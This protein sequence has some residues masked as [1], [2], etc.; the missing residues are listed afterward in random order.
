MWGAVAAPALVAA[1]ALVGNRPLAR[2]GAILGLGYLLAM[3]D[4]GAR[5]VVPGANDNASGVAA[6]LSVGHSLAADMPA[7]V[8]VIL[9]FPGSE[10]SFMEG[11]SAYLERHGDELP[12]A[13]TSVVCL[14]TVGS[15]M[16]LL[17][18]GEG[19]LRMRDYPRDFL[20]LLRSSAD[21]VGVKMLPNLRFRNATDGVI[22]LRA[23][24]PSA[25]IGSCDE[26]KLPTD[27]H[28][29][30]DTADRVNYATVADA[31]RVCRRAIERLA[32]SG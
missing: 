27:Y 17:L 3:L 28:W 22:A 2:F 30:T 18:E 13:T 9:L 26:F 32:A 21:E 14:D 19:M 4:I 11:M 23:G 1:A 16:L 29:P 15:P 12:T 20:A 31:A 7:G 10:E 5:P 8:R 25:M 6:L 24:Y